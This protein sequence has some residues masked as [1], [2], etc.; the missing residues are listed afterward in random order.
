MKERVNCKKLRNLMTLAT[1]LDYGF[2]DDAVRYK[3][4]YCMCSV[5]V[6]KEE[7]P[8]LNIRKDQIVVTSPIIDNQENDD[9]R[10]IYRTI[11]I[12]ADS[13]LFIPIVSWAIEFTKQI[14]IMDMPVYMKKLH[15]IMETVLLKV[16]EYEDVNQSVEGVPVDLLEPKSWETIMEGKMRWDNYDSLA[17]AESLLRN[18]VIG[19]DEILLPHAH[20]ENI[21]FFRR[22]GVSKDVIF[23]W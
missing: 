3:G 13:G 11:D 17:H 4:M 7:L 6:V 2:F 23:D 5:A 12:D 18:G 9:S 1:E 16:W 21:D 20:E 10:I 22:A 8:V 14:L 19:V 15:G